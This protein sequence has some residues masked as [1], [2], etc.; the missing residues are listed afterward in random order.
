[1]LLLFLIGLGSFLGHACISV[2][3]KLE[4]AGRVVIFKYTE[5]VYAFLYDWFM[6]L[7][8]A[9][10][11]IVGAALIAGSLLTITLLNSRA[12]KSE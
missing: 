9:V 2:A 1:M 4:K 6:G 7:S 5:M 10:T 8:I 11:D 12:K 3:Y